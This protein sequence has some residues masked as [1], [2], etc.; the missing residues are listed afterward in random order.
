MAEIILDGITKR[1]PDGTTAVRSL[2]LT[3]A[4]GELMVLRSAPVRVRRKTSP[5]VPRRA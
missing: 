1:Y 5:A 2:D 4:D 3:I